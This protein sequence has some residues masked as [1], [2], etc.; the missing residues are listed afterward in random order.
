MTDTVAAAPKIAER[1]RNQRDVMGEKSKLHGKCDSKRSDDAAERRRTNCF[2]G[3]PARTRL[4][5][6]PVTQPIAIRVQP[7]I[8]RPVAKDKQREQDDNRQRDEGRRRCRRGKAEAVN[9]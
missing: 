4:R 6:S 7:H 9:P 1:R 3:A 5:T 2:G 8:L